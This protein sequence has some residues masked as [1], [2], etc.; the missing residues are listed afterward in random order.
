VIT[1]FCIRRA[2]EASPP[3]GLSVP[4]GGPVR[5]IEAGELGAWVCDGELPRHL[6]EVRAHDA[7]VR[8][9]LR[10]STPLPV[11]FGTTFADEEALRRS[12]QERREEL[13]AGLRRVEGKVEMGI[14]VEWLER[15][16]RGERPDR[17]TEATGGR[18]YLE[19]RRREL[20][21]AEERRLRAVA[22]LEAVERRI[23]VD[24]AESLQR[25]LPAPGVAGVMA[26]LVQR[27]G[28]A[29]YRARVEEVRSDFPE[30]TLHV[31]GPW[32]PYSFV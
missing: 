13:L 10:S 25:P 20:M 14:R 2:G 16:P 27:Q 9:A 30:V 6:D 8:A 28:V 3:P 4:E 24:A 29:H 5:L 26:H 22:L 32:A 12:L 19:A 1:L 23:G 31:T 17:S 15:D 7:V 21:A 11:R 18:Q